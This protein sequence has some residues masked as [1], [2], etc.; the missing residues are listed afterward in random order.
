MLL[1]TC[2]IRTPPD[3]TTW[4]DFKRLLNTCLKIIDIV[5]RGIGLTSVSDTHSKAI[6]LTELQ[7]SYIACRTEV[8]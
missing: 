5:T 2:S 8:H 1:E 3:L 4:T 7:G 6:G